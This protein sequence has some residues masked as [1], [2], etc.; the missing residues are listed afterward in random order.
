MSPACPC[1]TGS[2]YLSDNKEF[3]PCLCVT[4]EALTAAEAQRDDL[5]EGTGLAERLVVEMLEA[6]KEARAAFAN[7]LVNSQGLDA[8]PVTID[9]PWLAELADLLDRMEPTEEEQKALNGECN[10]YRR[11]AR[12]AVELYEYAKA[13]FALSGH[14][15][16][17]NP[18]MDKRGR[19][20]VAYI[21]GGKTPL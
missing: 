20:I 8:N 10:R 4:P 19:E 1:C 2:H 17:I 7:F 21:D 9:D 15:V 5:L 13:S 3:G 18:D 11:A 14:P 6:V 16:W 12:Y